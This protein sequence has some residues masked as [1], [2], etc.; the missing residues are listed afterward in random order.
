MSII[1]VPKIL[2]PKKNINL[3]KW[4]CIACDQYTSEAEYWNELYNYVKSN[5]S[6][7]HLILPE[8]FLEKDTTAQIESANRHM[9]EYL[10]E[11]LFDLYEGMVL[12]ERKT[13]YTDK[14]LGLV[15]S[16]DLEEYSF[17]NLSSAS[18]VASEM[19]VTERIPPRV[20]I[21]ENAVLESPHILVLINDSSSRIIEKLYQE[22]EKYPVLYD[23]DLNMNGGHLKGYYIKDTEE[24]ISSFDRLEGN[25]KMVVGDGNHSL[26][27]AKVCWDNLKKT[28]TEEEQLS[29]PAR[30]A[31]VEVISIYDEG[32]TFEPI[33]RVLFN[34]EPDF[35]PLL[36]NR[37]KGLSHSFVYEQ[38]KKILF[39]HSLNP[40]IAIKDIQ[41]F[42]DEYL[43]NHQKTRIDFVHGLDSL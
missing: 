26:A 7:L 41:S 9:L 17:S 23:F 8:V 29:H 5:V 16:I 43:I 4:A 12:V 21:R 31:L 30:Y 3:S 6:T 19:T 40:F 36:L 11:D 42:L 18:I 25:I 37:M 34:V 10:Q 14:R 27:S 13:P 2:I 28:L 39:N 33:H 20:K 32:L 38:N 24:I 35:I 15:L 1:S 22:K